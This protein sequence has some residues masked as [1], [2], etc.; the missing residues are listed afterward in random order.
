MI[1]RLR[2]YCII[3]H[4]HTVVHRRR[5]PKSTLFSGGVPFEGATIVVTA[6][7]SPVQPVPGTLVTFFSP[8]SVVLVL[9]PRPPRARLPCDDPERVR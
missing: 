9:D 5:R 6:T 7:L 8:Y 3:E 2:T 4:L 1:E